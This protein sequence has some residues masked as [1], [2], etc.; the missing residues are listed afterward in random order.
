MLKRDT[1]DVKTQTDLRE[2]F[3]SLGLILHYTLQN[4]NAGHLKFTQ[5][6]IRSE[7]W[8]ETE[9]SISE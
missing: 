5:S 8:V 3:L 1:E 6:K 9:Y 2:I 7:R 4:K